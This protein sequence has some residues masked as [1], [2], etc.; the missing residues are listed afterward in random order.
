MSSYE[1]GRVKPS[2]A[3]V[4][5]LVVALRPRPSE[6]VRRRSDELK[7]LARS[8]RIGNVRVF[9]SA[10]TGSDGPGSDVDLLVSVERGVGLFGLSAFAL[11]AEDLLGVP[12]DVVSDGALDPR[13][14]LAAEAVPL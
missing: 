2:E 6:V 4:E 3:T 10:A 9:G 5:R 1:A 14:E 13:S 8:H 7:A 11:A 12:V